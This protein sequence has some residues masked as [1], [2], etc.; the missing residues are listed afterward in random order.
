MSFLNLDIPRSIFF[1]RNSIKYKTK[2]VVAVGVVGVKAVV[3]VVKTGRSTT[4]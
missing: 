3:G 2:N 4:T 1:A